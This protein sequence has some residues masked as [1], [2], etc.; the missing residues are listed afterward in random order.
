MILN[1]RV[2][3]QPELSI[4]GSPVKPKANIQD[5]SITAVTSLIQKYI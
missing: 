1:S 5:Y 4:L 2:K 3:K